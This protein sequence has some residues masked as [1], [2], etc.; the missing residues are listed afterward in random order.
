M[1]Y[2]K[3][4]FFCVAL[5]LIT[6]FSCNKELEIAQSS[7]ATFELYSPEQHEMNQNGLFFIDRTFSINQKS[8]III[9]IVIW[10][11]LQMSKV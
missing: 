1:I 2:F 3:S 4:M 9:Q 10:T 8:F 11:C 7:V 6:L 5:L